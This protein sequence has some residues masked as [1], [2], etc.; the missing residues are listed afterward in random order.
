MSRN[1]L[2]HTRQKQGT[3]AA[4][5]E[6]AKDLALA[7]RASLN[8]VHHQSGII[9]GL[10]FVQIILNALPTM[11]M[12]L[13]KQ[14]QIVLVNQTM[15]D[16]LGGVTLESILGSRPGEVLG[17]I[18]AT[19]EPD[20]CG[21]AVHCKACGALKSLLTCLKG[22]PD[23]QECRIIR[24]PEKALP[25][26]DLSVSATPL[27]ADEDRFSVFALTDI[28]HETRR[29]ALE[30]IFFHDVLN[31]AGGL[32]GLASLL[33][34]SAQDQDLTEMIHTTANK[35]IHQINSQK[36]LLAA[37]TNELKIKPS[38]VRS[39]DLLNKAVQ[40]Y[41]SHEVA[42]GRELILD[43]QSADVDFVTDPILFSRVIDNMIKNALEASQPGQA[44]EVGCRLAEN[45][46]EFCVHNQS[47]MPEEVQLQVF[48]R[49][50]TT[51]GAGRGLGTYSMWL[52][53]HRYL[54]GRVWFE[55]S[56]SKGTTFLARYPL[57][58]ANA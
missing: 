21:T 45:Q 54:G 35:I 39:L 51:K 20:G 17:C 1:K 37:E 28:S 41:K 57:E 46:V 13:N 12:I 27:K 53:S 8:K 16:F 10:P 11:I 40:E 9:L 31:T 14:R 25:A 22:Q 34:E 38:R 26:L 32:Q 30:R 29:R 2:D 48:E 42:A 19:E 52:L 55:S 5:A 23:I 18:H 6:A 33:K 49:S 4:K 44:V 47:V 50:F 36:I 15:L 58:L 24:A 56:P 7:E 3:S 43:S